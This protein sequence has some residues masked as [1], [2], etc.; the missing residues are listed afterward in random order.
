MNYLSE[1]FTGADEIKST[2][3]KFE[4]LCE[5]GEL[6]KALEKLETLES[7]I[8]LSKNDIANLKAN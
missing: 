5:D 1:L 4:T 8:G 7:L 2:A 6:D 3:A